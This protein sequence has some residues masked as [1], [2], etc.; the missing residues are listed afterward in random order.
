[1]GKKKNKTKLLSTCCSA[2]TKVHTSGDEIDKVGCTN[3]M[4]CSKCGEPC[5]FYT[6]TRGVWQINPV[7]KVIPNKKKKSSTKLTSGELKRIHEGEDF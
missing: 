5:N 4:V 1:M 7:T 2:E 3:Y 6:K